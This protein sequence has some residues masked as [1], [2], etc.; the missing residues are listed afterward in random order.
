MK[1]V[2]K[3]I[4][5]EWQREFDLVNT[6]KIRE[7]TELWETSNHNDRTREFILAWL[8]MNTVKG[9]HLIP[10]IKGTY[11]CTCQCDGSRLDLNHVFFNCNYY[12][13]Q[14]LPILEELSNNNLNFNVKFLLS[15]NENFCDLTLE[16]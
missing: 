12:V 5:K 15:D 11:P 16:F 2:R 13:V 7:K 8:R 9:I 4:I 14:R 1:Q 10:H 3:N 6:Y